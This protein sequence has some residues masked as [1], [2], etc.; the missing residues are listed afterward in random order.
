MEDGAGRGGKTVFTI[1]H[2]TRPLEELVRALRRYGVERLIDIRHFP[3]SRH[4]PQFNKAILEEALPR[5][6]IEYQTL[7]A[8]GGYRTGGYQAH[9]ETEEFRRGIEALEALAAEK[10]MAYMCAEVKWWRCH[11][12]RVSDVLA[13]RD[14]TVVHIFDERRAEIHTAKANVIKCD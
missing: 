2:S 12:R 13:E 8:L 3:A 5:E 1:G 10:R 4:N 11:R 9:M 14:W 6:G 7:E